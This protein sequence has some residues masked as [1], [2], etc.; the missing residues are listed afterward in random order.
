MAGKELDHCDTWDQYIVTG[1]RGRNPPEF[2]QYNNSCKCNYCPLMFDVPAFDRALIA[3]IR[4]T[5][6]NGASSQPPPNLN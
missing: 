5:S 2:C 6:V 1:R 4:N 3:N